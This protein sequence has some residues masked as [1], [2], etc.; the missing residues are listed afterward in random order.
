MPRDSLALPQD[1]CAELGIDQKLDAIKANFK[2]RERQVSRQYALTELMHDIEYLRAAAQD[3]QWKL[4][5]L[6]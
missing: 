1:H 6:S 4:R 3:E 5:G 2:R